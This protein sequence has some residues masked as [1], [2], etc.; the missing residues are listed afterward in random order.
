MAAQYSEGKTP[1]AA[2]VE[3]SSD[4]RNSLEKEKSSANKTLLR[5][6]D[7]RLIPICATMY[8]LAYLD[9]SNIGNAKVMNSEEGHDLMTETNI[10]GTQYAIALMV[11]LIAYT[12]FEVPANTF[13]KRLGPSKWF[14]L[15]LCCW[16]TISMCLGAVHNYAGLTA[17][18]FMLGIFEAGLAPGLAYYISF[19]YRA[20]ERSLRLAFIYSTATLAGAFGGLIAYGIS[21]MNQVAGISGWRWL[22]ILEGAPSVLFGIFIF[23]Y[24][25][26]YPETAKF[27]TTEEK[28]LAVL[29]MEHN[30]SKGNAAH[31]T[32]ADAK[33]VLT[34]W[35]LYIH[36]IV[37]FSKSCP[38]SSLSLFTP[39]ITKGLGYS[40]LQA[41]LMTVPPYAAAFVVTILLSFYCDRYEARAMTTIGLMLVGAAGF[42]GSAC[43][44]PT[45]YTSR[46][47]C[48]VIAA[49]GTFATI[50]ILLGWLSA[51]LRSTSA[52]G[53]ALALNISFGAPGQILG[54]WIYKGSE[55]KK[56]YPTGHWING[57]LL[58]VGSV[59]TGAL[60][61]LYTYRNRRIDK[62]LVVD[63]KWA[64]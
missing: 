53:L 25:P 31:M 45:S 51:N 43:L 26:D 30:G 37:Y 64:L 13:L 59:L 46:Y 39:S 60:V 29:R 16:G 44:P 21:H 14:A 36:Y 33:E 54:V 1:E 48:L 6:Q 3:D 38:F 47:A 10:S 5:K 57:A 20:N 55:Q 40:S 2:F 62:G 24:L 11:F 7:F 8:L 12:L 15:L 4:P 42:I 34:D 49:C 58:L 28:E 18:R 63:K 35:R 23:F 27:L 17:A 19:W 32:W 9:R 56:G 41:Q 52:Q 50:P 22:F 61:A